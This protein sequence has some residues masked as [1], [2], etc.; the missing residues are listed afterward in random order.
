[1]SVFKFVPE[2]NLISVPVTEI[3]RYMGIYGKPSQAEEKLAMCALWETAKEANPQVCYTLCPIERGE[4]YVDA[5]FGR[6]ESVS[7]RKLLEG[8]SLAV[9]FAATT[10]AAVDRVINRLKTKD[11]SEAVAADAA[12]T[13]FAEGLCELFCEHIKSGLPKGKGLTMRFSPGYGDLPLTLQ[14]DIFTL[15][16]C[17][18]NIGLTLTESLMMAPSKSVTAVMGI[19]NEPTPENCKD[20][21]ENCSLT[22]CIYRK[23]ENK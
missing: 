2:T 5:G 8:C 14:K 6:V 4:G 9:V 18:K 1:M 19:K 20:K 17:P 11:I 7:L 10:G 12:A 23:E 21:C 22:N 16:N 15:L 3:Y 13:A